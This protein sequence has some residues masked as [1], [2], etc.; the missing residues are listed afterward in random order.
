MQAPE[1]S[2]A[3]AV[4]A[5]PRGPAVPPRLSVALELARAGLVAEAV[6]E[7]G[8]LRASGPLEPLESAFALA[9]GIECRLA[10][11]DVGEALALGEELYPHLEASGLT[12]AVAHHARGELASALNE[13]EG[14]LPFFE[15]AGR[16]VAGTPDDAPDVLPW[17]VG[18]ALAS[19]RLGRRREASALALAHLARARPSGSPYALAQALR[20]LATTVADGNRVALLREARA[21]LDGTR[22]LRLGAQIDTDLAGL[23]LLPGDAHRTEALDLL[24]AAEEYA[25]R[26][27]LW[28][29]QNRVRRLLERLGQSPRRVQSEALEALT[30]SERKVAR[31]AAQGLTNR[32]IAQELVV[33]VKAV[34]WHLSHIYRKL[35]IRSRT[36][37]AVTLGVLV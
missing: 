2:T 6:A 36:R 20:T 24:R 32:Q 35:G 14:A 23:L 34:E 30:I 4:P 11:G 13:T 18:A 8:A 27:E 9:C 10:R 31:L 19:L 3:R 22:A 25:G 7:L 26:Q 21:V 16:L 33:T 15:E 5:G 37:L 1:V 12:G 17:R 29:L 28:P